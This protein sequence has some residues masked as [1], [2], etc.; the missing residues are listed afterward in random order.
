METNNTKNSCNCPHCGQLINV[1][2]LLY[3]QIQS[4]IKSEYFQQT[5]TEKK[6][7]EKK[8]R[9]EISKETSLEIESYKEQLENKTTEVKELN[10]TKAELIR[11]QREKDELKEKIEVESEQKL[12]KALT[13][14]KIKIRKSIEDESQLR[15]IEKELLIGQLTDQVKDMQKKIAQGSMQL[16]GETQEILIENYLRDNFPLDEI[17]EIK[18]GARG[19]DCIQIINSRTHQNCGS[20]YYE[21]KNTKEF[22]P[23][24]IEKFKTD[25]REKGAGFGILVT[26]VYPKGVE[27]MILKGGI[28]ICKL[29][30]FKALCF[31][32]RESILML[33]NHS[34]S[35]ENK[36]EKMQML[37]DYLIGSEF[38]MQVEAIVE[39]FM[40]MNIDLEKE[41]VATQSLWKRRK[42]QIEKILLNTNHMFSSVK[43]IA[44]E[45]ITAIKL[46]ELPQNV[47][48]EGNEKFSRNISA[49]VNHI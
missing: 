19:A 3:S 30:E 10:K 2:E 38:K 16:Q 43:G 35:Q 11:V 49:I 32:L 34:I 21:S 12:S 45:S 20:I 42:K 8:L 27:R 28:W 9:V 18:K 4:E 1:S 31:V 36:G 15:M 13:E 41:M 26:D 39:G 25:M 29:E 37:Y 14:E 17:Q 7:L 47:K 6:E 24:W 22:Q 33:H 44:G 46:L 5:S 48:E 40:Q 23:A